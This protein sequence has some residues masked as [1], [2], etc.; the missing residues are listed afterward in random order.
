M[1]LAEPDVQLTLGTTMPQDQADPPNIGQN[2]HTAD[3]P[4][5]AVSTVSLRLPQYWECNPTVWVLQVESQFHI[6]RIAWQFQKFHHVVSS[7]PPAAAE[8]VS[9]ILLSF[10]TNLPAALY[11]ELKAALLEKTAASEWMRIQQLLSTAELGDRRPT[12]LLRQL[13]QL[14]GSRA[15]AMDDAVL[16]ELLFQRF[17]S[18]VQMVLANTSIMDLQSLAALAD[19]VMEVAT[20]HLQ[21]AAVSTHSTQSPS[22][23]AASNLTT[24]TTSPSHTHHLCGRLEE[25]IVAATR[26]DY[27]PRRSRQRG[28]SSTPHRAGE[29]DRSESTGPSLCY[30]HRRFGA[31]ARHCLLPCAWTGNP[32]P[33]TS[34]DKRS[35]P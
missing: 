7:L 2:S 19:K 27:A 31:E 23:C 9:D 35:G 6:Y 5:D 22:S 25:L 32:L 4:G 3:A 1:A 18:N 11:N 28:R 26:Q 34:G 30:Y 24:A 15:H 20:Q 14:I 29:R 16:R 13:M 21:V 12:Q 17:P 10:R 33:T 8:E